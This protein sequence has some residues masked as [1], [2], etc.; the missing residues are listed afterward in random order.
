MNIKGQYI[1]T[2][3]TFVVPLDNI[4]L[5]FPMRYNS[6]TTHKNKNSEG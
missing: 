3:K 1:E 5:N 2:F 4:K 6:V